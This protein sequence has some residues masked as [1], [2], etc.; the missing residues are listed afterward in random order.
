MHHE[1]VTHYFIIKRGGDI[2]FFTTFVA[3][4]I[5]IKEKRRPFPLFDVCIIA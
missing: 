1:K 3:D 4:F 2:T 5:V